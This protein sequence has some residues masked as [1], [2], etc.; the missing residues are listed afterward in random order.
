MEYLF[1]AFGWIPERI[2]SQDIKSFL[3]VKLDF[4]LLMTVVM[5]ALTAVLYRI[6]RVVGDR[7]NPQESG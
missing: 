2:G 4:T 3:T 1:A 6:A 7:E 5:L